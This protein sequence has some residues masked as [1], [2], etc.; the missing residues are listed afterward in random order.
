MSS[1]NIDFEFA[2]IV[3]ARGRT[4]VERPC[5]FFVTS[6]QFFSIISHGNC[7]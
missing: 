2:E 6:F 3:I 1:G 4:L 5:K 7:R